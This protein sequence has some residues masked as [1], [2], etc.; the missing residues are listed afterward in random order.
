MGLRKWLRKK[1]SQRTKAFL[2]KLLPRVLR[3][4]VR[5][6]PHDRTL[7]CKDMYGLKNLRGAAS[8]CLR[9]SVLVLRRTGQH[10]G[11][12]LELYLC[13]PHLAFF[14]MQTLRVTH[15]TQTPKLEMVLL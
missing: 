14:L 11:R 12:G 6:P 3:M 2:A 4:H 13:L 1:R 5:S 8:P 15:Q 9:P 7:M 10:K